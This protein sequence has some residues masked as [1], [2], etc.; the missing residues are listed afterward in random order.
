MRNSSIRITIAFLRKQRRKRVGK[1]YVLSYPCSVI[2]ERPTL[3]MKVI[4][5]I[6]RLTDVDKLCARVSWG[7]VE[8]DPNGAHSLPVGL[9]I[10]LLKLCPSSLEC[11]AVLKASRVFHSRDFETGSISNSEKIEATEKV[12]MALVA[13]AKEGKLEAPIKEVLIRD[14]RDLQQSV[15]RQSRF[16][17]TGNHIYMY[18]EHISQGGD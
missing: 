4:D 7:K 5:A 6:R 14:R 8:G 9:L 11:I 10:S 2:S 17:K 15:R 1:V 18:A 16:I 3:D 12:I 13:L